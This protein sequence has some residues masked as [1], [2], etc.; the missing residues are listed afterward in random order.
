MFLLIFLFS[1]SYEL[2]ARIYLTSSNEY[3]IETSNFS[4]SIYTAV[5]YYNDTLE[6]K[7]WDTLSIKTNKIFSDE[8]QME[9][10]GRLEGYLTRKRIYNHYINCK[11]FIDIKD[12]SYNFLVEQ[13][14]FIVESYKKNPENIYFY[15]GNLILIQ[16][17]SLI[18]EYNKNSEEEK[19]IDKKGFY[20]LQHQADLIEINDKYYPKNIYNFT[21]EE[22]EN[23]ILEKT[24]CSSL[25]KIKE[26]LSDI[27]FGHNTWHYYGMMTRIFKEYNINLNHPLIKNK[28]VLFSSYPGTLNSLD[29]FYINSKSNLIV[30]ETTNIFFNQTLY[31]Y[32][33][34]NNILCWQRVIIANF[35]SNSS[36]EWTQ[37]FS[38][39]NSGTYNDM[40]MILDMK[41]VNLEKGIIEDKSFYIIETLPNYIFINDITNY[42]IRSYWPSYNTPF[43]KENIKISNISNFIK[44]FPEMKNA[45]DYNNNIRAKI[46]RRE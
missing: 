45:S 1:L 29:D 35:L 15:L 14:N 30:I 44:E 16:F 19:K 21:K 25:F 41:K 24:H 6:K 42:L 8:I 2:E 4:S 28:N 43:D 22:L 38:K 27:F 11:S 33:H 10:A 9:S 39:Y 3:I 26:D 18:N 36:F 7:G 31:D 37:H 23:Y 34:P 13:E 17:N 5:A 12:K 46:F 20:Y 32:I 40:F